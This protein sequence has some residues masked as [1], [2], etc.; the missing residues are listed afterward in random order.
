MNKRTTITAATLLSIGLWAQPASAIPVALELAL[1]VDVSGSIT[2]RE[3]ELQKLGYAQAF[4]DPTIQSLIVNMPGGIAVTYV[5]FSSHQQQLQQVDWTLLTDASGSNAFADA[6]AG[7]ERAFRGSTAVGSALNFTF[8]LF[9]NDFEGQRLAIDISADGPRNTGAFASVARDRALA[10]GI[11]VI[12]ALPI[13]G[14][15]SDLDLWFRDNVV[16]GEGSFYI[17]ARGFEDFAEAIR[18]KLMREFVPPESIP[19]PEPASLLLLALALLQLGITRRR[20]R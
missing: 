12:N 3:Y 15:E 2:D 1:V 18:R 9:N 17:L 7:T 11:S 19:L 20:V 8:P 13:L 5:E 16:G 6:I 10:A 14:D 4:G